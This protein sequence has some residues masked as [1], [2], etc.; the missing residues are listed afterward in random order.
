M[1]TL[2]SEL[3]SRH[4]RVPIL[5]WR[6]LIFDLR[7]SGDGRRESG[8]FLLGSLRG[9][10]PITRSYV[11]YHDLDPN[12]YQGGGIAFHAAGCAAL[13]SY[14]RES[15]LEILADVHTHP[16]RSTRQS[17]TDRRNPMLPL[18]GHIALIV[19]N[20]ASTPWWSIDGVGVYE[21]LGNFQWRTD[22]DRSAARLK[23]SLW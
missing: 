19:P 10:T 12:A 23:L 14:C 8:A 2:V 17:E 7:R 11:C 22:N 1:I 3:H 18:V 13:W 21:Y 16:G 20:F 6:R 4:I 15:S 5:L 9:P